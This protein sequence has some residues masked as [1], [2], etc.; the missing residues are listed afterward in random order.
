M[1]LGVGCSVH[2]AP[3][4]SVAS[5]VMYAGVASDQ[6]YDVVLD[7][8]TNAHNLRNFVS[9]SF[10]LCIA[11]SVRIHSYILVLVISLA[12]MEQMLFYSHLRRISSCLRTHMFIYTKVLILMK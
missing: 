9:M 4:Q 6:F 1:R 2:P 3:E 12:T 8:A 10:L 5:D 11:V 7:D